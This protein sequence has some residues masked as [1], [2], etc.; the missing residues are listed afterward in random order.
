MFKSQ[1]SLCLVAMTD[2]MEDSNPASRVAQV[3]GMKVP[4]INKIHIV[5]TAQIDFII[6]DLTT[7]MI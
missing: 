7:M 3:L 6:T 2:P 5:R 1:N 4:G